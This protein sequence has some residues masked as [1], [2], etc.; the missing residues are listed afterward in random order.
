ME[1]FE[2]S[3]EPGTAVTLADGVALAEPVGAGRDA[4]DYINHSCSPN[5]GMLDALTVRTLVDVGAGDELTCD[6]AYWLVRDDYEM[7]SDCQCFGSACRRRITGRDWMLPA[8]ADAMMRNAS[9]YIRRRLDAML[10]GKD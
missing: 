5:L 2:A 10:K 8:L 7:K 1:G 4:S 3:I 9:P 6:Y